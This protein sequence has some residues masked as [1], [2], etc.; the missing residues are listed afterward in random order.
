MV[1]LSQLDLP[2]E[3][4]SEPDPC[5]FETISSQSFSKG[6]I[7]FA[8]GLI[9]QSTPEPLRPHL[10]GHSFVQVYAQLTQE[11]GYR[12]AHF[13]LI[14]QS[15]DVKNI[16][17]SFEVDG[18]I[19]IQLLNGEIITLKHMAKD[20]GTTDKLD[21]TLTYRTKSLITAK[22]Q[23]KLQK[24]G[25]DHITFYWSNSHEDFNISNPYYI[26]DQLN[27]LNSLK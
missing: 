4:Q 22:M 11:P 19:Q 6:I 25:I 9:C 2:I 17:G 15:P 13:K 24:V 8:S 20:N 21:H 10:T 1:G 12:F 23:K 26:H 16:Y 18:W 7:R 14:F 27:C 5:T 3:Q